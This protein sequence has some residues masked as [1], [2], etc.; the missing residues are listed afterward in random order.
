MSPWLISNEALMPYR[1]EP[2]IQ[3]PPVANYLRAQQ[4]WGLDLH[5]EVEVNGEVVT[6]VDFAGHYWTPAQQLAH[7]TVNG[8]STRPG[9]LVASG[10]VSGPDPGTEGSL[11]E[12]GGPFLRDGDVVVLRGWAGD[13]ALDLGEVAG[14]VVSATGIDS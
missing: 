1:I 2:P 7:V 9:D 5:L 13:H 8:A 12:K 14:Q 4:P 6:R 3:D 10:T 11:I